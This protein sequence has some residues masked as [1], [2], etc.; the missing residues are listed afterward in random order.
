MAQH[1]T[2]RAAEERRSSLV[3]QTKRSSSEYNTE[4]L[5]VTFPTIA[6]SLLACV[7]AR[8]YAKLDRPTK[9]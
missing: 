3:T 6:L 5:Y 7:L 8:Y 2:Q 9:P 4:L 1:F